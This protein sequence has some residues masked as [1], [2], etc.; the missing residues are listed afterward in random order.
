MEATSQEVTDLCVKGK[1]T[2]RQ[3]VGVCVCVRDFWCIA[4]KLCD[5]EKGVE[6]VNVLLCESSFNSQ[7]KRSLQKIKNEKIA[8]FC[9]CVSSHNVSNAAVAPLLTSTPSL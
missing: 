5:G 6:G 8:C 9:L 4:V 7:L 1:E 3:S 2:S